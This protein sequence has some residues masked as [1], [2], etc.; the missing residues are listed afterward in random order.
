MKICNVSLNI[1]ALPAVIGAQYTDFFES[2]Q[3]EGGRS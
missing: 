2:L 3:S 1:V